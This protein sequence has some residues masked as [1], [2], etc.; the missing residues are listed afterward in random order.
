[1]DRPRTDDRREW[2][3]AWTVWALMVAAGL[4]FVGTYAFT[5]PYGDEWDWLPA[6]AGEQPVD[7]GWFWSMHNEH[8]MPVPRL[9]YMGLGE[10]TGF[11][12]RAGPF[13]IIL[14][15]SGLAMALM[16]GARALRGRTSVYD[17]FFPLLLLHWGQC[18]NLI[19]GFQIQF[20]ASVV[21]AGVVLLLIV[22][23]GPRLG[24]A[25]AL[26]L[27]LFAVGLG[28]C[29]LNGLVYL[30][31]LAC[32]LAF[33]G[34]CRWRDPSPGS[35]RDGL[36]LMGLACSLLALVVVYFI[37]FRRH[38][39]PSPGLWASLSTALQ[40]LSA[41]LG[42]GA[43][44]I[45][46]VSG[47]LVATTC[48]YALWQLYAVFRRRPDERVRAA[49]L[50]CFLGG[51]GAMALAVGVGR[52]FESPRA[53]F[54]PRY[55]TLAAPLLCLFY[56]QFTLYS[57]A[58]VTIHLQRT[59]ALLMGGLLLVNMPKGLRYA[60]D[61]DQ[62]LTQ[63]DAD[64]RAGLSADDLAVRYGDGLGFAPNDIFIWRLEML[65]RAQL[66]P[67]RDDVASDGR[68]LSV[69]PFNN[70]PRGCQPARRA[71]LL[72]G[73]SLTQYFDVPADA[74]PCRI[75]VQTSQRWHRT[76]DRVNWD[77]YTVSPDQPR[78]LLTH[79]VIDMR[80]I[81]RDD[82]V[83]L[84]I[85]A[86]NAPL[87]LGEGPGVR[88]IRLAL[89]FSPPADSRP[90]HGVEFPLY[91]CAE[92]TENPIE[93]DSLTPPPDVPLSLKGFCFLKRTNEP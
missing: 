50:F 67:Y 22:S 38:T 54:M 12:F 25:R 58:R 75:D 83:S 53:G 56:L 44:E 76:L 57:S 48:G 29:G 80:P 27:T 17:A 61:F 3:V 4:W 81:D 92:P 40:F 11:D 62:R 23:C 5:M 70:L 14:A 34:V 32:W 69:C 60:N 85:F 30:P 13:F 71:T 73:Q 82:Y 18:E 79:G 51:I 31:P 66:G 26:L 55:I 28:L 43:K 1:M 16:L 65:R 77:L 39:A 84:T 59:L 74:W 46:P 49:G 33:A 41:G 8:R 93:T 7:L 64:M 52:A 63:F 72:P 21:L 2:L 19:W 45:W 88:A 47:V 6:I 15:L 90:D 42:P 36:L 86:S 24:V 9:I 89:V 37:G 87:P 68:R 78:E 20:V 10:L 91:Q 35:R